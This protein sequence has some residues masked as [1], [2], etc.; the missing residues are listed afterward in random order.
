MSSI[1]L[2]DL[3]RIKAEIN[4]SRSSRHCRDESSRR[5]ILLRSNAPPKRENLNAWRRVDL[6]DRRTRNPCILLFS[7]SAA[8]THYQP[9]LTCLHLRIC[10]TGACEPPNNGNGRRCVNGKLAHYMLATTSRETDSVIV[11]GTVRLNG[12]ILI[13]FSI[14]TAPHSLL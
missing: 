12:C 10:C 14:T 1:D 8:A 11:D 7:I 6:T 4:Y 3:S 2:L 13:R 5:G 9:W